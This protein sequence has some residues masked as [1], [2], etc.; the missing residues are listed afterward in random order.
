MAEIFNFEQ[1][2]DM[3]FFYG[4]NDLAL[5]NEF[6]LYQI[7]TQPKRSLF[8]NR[9]ESCGLSEYENNPNSLSLQVLSRFDIANSVAYRNTVVPDGTNGTKDRRIALSQNSIGF[10]SKNGELDITILYFNFFNYADPKI[11]GLPLSS[12]GG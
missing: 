12:I 5:E 4:S 6:D 3:F 9:K 8:Y 1:A 2:W 11:F 7:I 10:S